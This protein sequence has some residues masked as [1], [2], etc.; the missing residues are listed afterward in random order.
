MIPKQ[1]TFFVDVEETS[2]VDGKVETKTVT[3]EFLHN[4][5]SPQRCFSNL[6]R[7][8]KAFAVPLVMM[9]SSNEEEMQERI[10]EALFMLFEQM[11]EQD[12]WNLFKLITDGI[13]VDGQP[14]NLDQDLGY[15][16]DAVLQIVA[17]ALSNNYG[18]LLS[19]KGFGNLISKMVPMA[20]LVQEK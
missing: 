16:L 20:Q 14:I 15:D 1:L 19:G 7:I 17:E 3:K 9:F 18:K 12:I 4:V 8:G 2:F 13:Y 11:E 5:W 10:P 6:P